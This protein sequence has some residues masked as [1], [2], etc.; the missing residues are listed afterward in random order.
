MR[1]L[2]AGLAARFDPAAAAGLRATIQFDVR[3]QQPGQ[4]YHE[5]R[6]GT[7]SFRAGTAENPTLTIHTAAEI[8][9]AIATGKLEGGKAF[10][11]GQYTVDGDLDLLRRFP[12]LFGDA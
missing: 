9:R 2:L 4:W 1:I 10:W 7:C 11:D 8:W 6:D 12:S 5:I 3:G